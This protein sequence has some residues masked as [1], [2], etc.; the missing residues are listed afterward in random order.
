ML[1]HRKTYCVRT[2]LCV[3]TGLLPVSGQAGATSIDSF[4]DLQVY[5]A[6]GSFS[7]NTKN[8]QP[9]PGSIFD[10]RELSV[11]DDFSNIT[12]SNENITINSSNTNGLASFNKGNGARN[13]TVTYKIDYS[14]S[15]GNSVDLSGKDQIRFEVFENDTS[16]P[17]PDGLEFSLTLGDQGQTDTQSFQVS[18]GVLLANLSAFNANLSNLETFGIENNLPATL[19]GE[20]MGGLLLNEVQA[21]AVPNVQAVPVPGTIGLFSVGLFGLGIAARRRYNA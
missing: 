2:A 17:A 4:T 14:T 6:S 13:D 11:P 10:T 16:T 18:D 19:N 1:S 15:S 12:P 7:S 9:V 20:N 3:L 5:E 8:L 21:V